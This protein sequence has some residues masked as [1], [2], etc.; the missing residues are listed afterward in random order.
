MLSVYNERKAT[1]NSRKYNFQGFF[2]SKTYSFRKEWM[3][4]YNPIFRKERT[5]TYKKIF[6][7][8]LKKGTKLPEGKKMDII[9][10]RTLTHR[11]IKCVWFFLC[12]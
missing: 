3:A 2:F 1:L 4:L 8:K 6:R 7:A 10:T 12:F 11:M 5:L 9:V